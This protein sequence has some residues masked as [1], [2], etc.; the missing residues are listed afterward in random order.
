M[1]LHVF[2][3]VRLSSTSVVAFDKYFVQGTRERLTIRTAC[4]IAYQVSTTKY[5]SYWTVYYWLTGR[6]SVDRLIPQ[7]NVLLYCFSF[8]EIEHARPTYHATCKYF[9]EYQPLSRSNSQLTH[10]KQL[11]FHE[12][13]YKK[14]KIVSCEYDRWMVETQLCK[15]R[16]TSDTLIGRAC[17]MFQLKCGVCELHIYD[18]V[19]DT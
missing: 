10:L 9:E 4:K 6:T 16:D 14:L 11:S 13:N 17:A 15:L 2:Q 8:K 18:M 19:V 12:K 3:V 5:Y 1:I 7:Y